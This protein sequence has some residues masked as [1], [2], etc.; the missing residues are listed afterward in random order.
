[1]AGRNYKFPHPDDVSPGQGAVLCPSDRVLALYNQESGAP[2]KAKS[3]SK[4]VREWFF[5]HAHQQ[6]WAGVRFLKDVQTSEASGCVL[7]IPPRE[8]N[9][10]V[11]LTAQTLVL[12]DSSDA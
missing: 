4:K 5:N 7:W 6:G 1:M 8:I 3:I 11:N 2:K 12:V 9:L 10:S